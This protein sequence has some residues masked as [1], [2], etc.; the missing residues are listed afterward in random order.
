LARDIEMVGNE[1]VDSFAWRIC[2]LISIRNVQREFL[3]AL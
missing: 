1:T 2:R 3:I